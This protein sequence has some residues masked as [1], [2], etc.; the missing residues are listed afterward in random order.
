MEGDVSISSGT[1]SIKCAPQVV[2]EL[3]E[4]T[5]AQLET[6]ASATAQARADAETARAELVSMRQEQ[7][8]SLSD[9]RRACAHLVCKACNR[10]ANY[11]VGLTAL[12]TAEAL[13]VCWAQRSTAQVIGAAV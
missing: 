13:I 9:V 12:K 11:R 5:A 8:V 3:R 2:E 6:A 10:S 4:E 7:L 1:I